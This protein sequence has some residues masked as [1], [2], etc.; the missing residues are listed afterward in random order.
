MTDLPTLPIFNGRSH[1]KKKIV[2]MEIFFCTWSNFFLLWK[3]LISFSNNYDTFINQQTCRVTNFAIFLSNGNILMFFWRLWYFF[4]S[5][6]HCN[7]SNKNLNC[8]RFFAS[9]RHVT[10]MADLKII[11]EHFLLLEISHCLQTFLE[12]SY[13][14]VNAKH[15]VTFRNKN[16]CNRSF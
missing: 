1:T 16:N 10:K 6:L 9:V 14:Q 8:V 12:T 7:K 13:Q 3:N 11:A 2:T 5:W 4:K 15:S